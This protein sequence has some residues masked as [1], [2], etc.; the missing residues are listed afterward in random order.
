MAADG[1]AGMI[2]KAFR[3]ARKEGLSIEDAAQIVAD[4]IHDK[5]EERGAEDAE[6][7][8]EMIKVQSIFGART[9]LPLVDFRYGLE[10]FTLP[11][12][13]ARDHALVILDCCNAATMD[14]AVFR[15]LTLSKLGL[16][17]RAAAAAI[18]ELR[19]FRGD[20]PREDWT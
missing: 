16:D 2:A 15:W 13:Q 3:E 6:V 18:G 9:G 19:R 1:L 14:A 20:V 10:H 11:V 12:E 4:V 17:Q 8:R 7:N 5:L